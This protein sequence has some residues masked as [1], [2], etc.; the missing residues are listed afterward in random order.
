M[1][2]LKGCPK[3]HGDLYLNRDI[4]GTYFQCVQCAYIRDLNEEE[5]K[6]IAARLKQRKLAKAA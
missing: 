1:L 2:I 6:V 5:Q 3:C 4:Y